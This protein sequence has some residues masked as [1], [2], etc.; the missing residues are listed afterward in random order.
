MDDT[1]ERLINAAGEVFS[2]E[3]FDSATVRAICQQAGAN[4]AA[5]NYH[6]G[7]KQR[8]YIEAVKTAHCQQDPPPDF[9]WTAA[10]PPEQKL[11]DFIG[12]MMELMVADDRPSWH[13]ELIMREMAR[14]TEACVELVR[15]FIGPMFDLLLEILGELLPPDTPLFERHFFGFSVVGQCLLYRYH[16]PVGRL[17]VGEDEFARYFDS[18]RIADHITRF[19]LA[20]VKA[21]CDRRFKPAE[22]TP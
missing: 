22:A 10:T 11:A 20:G 21:A 4:L 3:G 14:P 13:I 17:L 2:R 16:R 1:R 5:I 9:A 19:S 6:F 15:S 7:D 18:Q 8:L 12:H